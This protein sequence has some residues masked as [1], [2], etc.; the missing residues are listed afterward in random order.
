MRQAKIFFNGNSAGMFTEEVY[1]SKY[2]FKYF[3][4]YQGQPISLTLPIEQ[5]YYEFPRF[6]A[7]FDGLLPEGPQLEAIL[8][9]AKLDRS[10]YFGQLITV[11]KDLV[12]AITVEEIA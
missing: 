1:G 7:V 2:N 4:D 11:G 6:P 3:D 9:Y 12:G 8:R 5:K 10:D